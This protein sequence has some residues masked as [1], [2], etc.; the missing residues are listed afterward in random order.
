M[1]STSAPSGLVP[2]KLHAVSHVLLAVDVVELVAMPMAFGDDLRAVAVVGLAAAARGAVGWAPS[3][4]VPPLSVTLRLFVQQADHRM[5]CVLVEFGGVGVLEAD[6]VAAKLDGGTLHSQADAQE[7]NVAF[8]GKA[9][10]LDL[11]FDSPLAKPARDQNAVVAGQQ[12]LRALAFNRLA[13][14]ASDT[15][16]GIDCGCRRGPATRRSTCRRRS[17]RHTCRPRRC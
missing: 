12:P 2:A 4:M 8:P 16:L 15:H 5:G 13:Q 14:H 3:R 10:R 6:H 11:A 17:A 1:I 7:R 9:D